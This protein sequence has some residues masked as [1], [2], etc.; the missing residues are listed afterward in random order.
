MKRENRHRTI[1]RNDK[2]L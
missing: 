1:K 2:L